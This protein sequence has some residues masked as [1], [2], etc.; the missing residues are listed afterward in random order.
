MWNMSWRAR[1]RRFRLPREG[2][3]NSNEERES[4]QGGASCGF[5]TPALDVGQACEMANGDSGE[6]S[7]CPGGGFLERLQDLAETVMVH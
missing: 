5:G 7:P 1:L 2:E 3:E 4:P 6:S